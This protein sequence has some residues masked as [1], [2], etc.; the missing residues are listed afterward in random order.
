MVFIV[1]VLVTVLIV[2]LIWILV[3]QLRTSDWIKRI[4]E[5]TVVALA[6]VMLLQSIGMLP[7]NLRGVLQ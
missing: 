5:T 4:L 7:F 6:I 2:L 3:Q 1:N